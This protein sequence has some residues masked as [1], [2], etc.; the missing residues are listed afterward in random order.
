MKIFCS[1]IKNKLVKQFHSDGV[2]TAYHGALG[3]TIARRKPTSKSGVKT[4]T[5]NFPMMM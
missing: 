2:F 5:W 1:Q 3:E 4:H